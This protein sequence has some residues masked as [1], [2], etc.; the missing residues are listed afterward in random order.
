M[1]SAEVEEHVIP[2]GPGRETSITVV[3]PFEIAG[4][5]P[6]VLYVHGA[7]WVLGNFGTHERLV[8]ELAT[9][10]GAAVVFVNYSPSPEAQFPMAIE[11]V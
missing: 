6:G 2:G 7:G 4:A 1:P 9:G 10:A 5:P 11:E 8:L 3:R